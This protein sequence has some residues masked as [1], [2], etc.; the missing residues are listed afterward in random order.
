MAAEL[1]ALTKV[2]NT[3]PAAEL[4]SSI[5]YDKESEAHKLAVTNNAMALCGTLFPT[6]IKDGFALYFYGKAKEE[7]KTQIQVILFL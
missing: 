5:L 7:L 4:L 1:S 2:R 6:V 3:P